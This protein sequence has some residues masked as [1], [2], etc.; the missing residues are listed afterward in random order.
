M[1]LKIQRSQRTGG[2]FG[3][4]VFFCLDV[5]A[6]YFDEETRNIN[7]YKLAGEVIYS[8]ANARKHAQRAAAHLDSMQG[9]TTGGMAMGLL[10]GGFSAAMANMQLIVTIGSL[11]GGHR[12]ECRDLEELLEAEQ[13]IMEACKNLQGYLRVAKTFDGSTTLIDFSDTG[14]AVPHQTTGAMPVISP[15]LIEA[16]SQP[17]LELKPATSA[18]L[19]AA[20]QDAQDWERNPAP[21]DVGYE[22]GKGLRAFWANP[23]HRIGVY[24]IGG[25]LG[26]VFFLHLIL[27][28]HS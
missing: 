7:K 11:A 8:S 18:E 24:C 13:T 1:Q 6:A 3:G 10:K 17:L 4:K 22:L 15:P 9:A 23:E 28:G 20:E 25:I 16:S 12:I 19:L 27:G 21:I 2:A 5:R 14:E 26:F